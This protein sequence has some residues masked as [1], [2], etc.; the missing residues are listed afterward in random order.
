IERGASK[1]TLSYYT[2]LSVEPGSIVN[3]SI[4]RKR[5]PALVR[6]ISPIKD[7]RSDLRKSSFLLKKLGGSPKIIFRKEFIDTC[8]ETASYFATTV[9]A[10]LYALSPQAILENIDKIDN[11]R[12]RQNTGNI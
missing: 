3:V 11:L 2:G 12:A 5:I 8:I 1:E 9:G 4:R 7:L 6:E 10:L